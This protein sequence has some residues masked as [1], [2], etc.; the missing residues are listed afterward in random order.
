MNMIPLKPKTVI[1]LGLRGYSVHRLS[2]EDSRAIQALFDKCL[3]F[4]L[5]V[6]GH[7]AGA[8]AG[9]EE[10]QDVPPGRSPA[11]KLMLGIFDQQG[12]L[13][14]LLDAMKDY[15]DEG[16][17]WIGLLLFLPEVRS[18]GLGHVVVS[19]FAEYVQGNGGQAIML[20][21]VEE[22]ERAY[23][24]WER[25][26]FELVSKTEPRRFGDKTQTV[27]VMRKLIL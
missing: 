12:A 17:W 11:D 10:F 18:Q 5:L 1:S 21:V 23:Q 16:T 20:G 22:N 9:E 8:H 27:S 24:F 19:W 3:D 7:P 6:D 4:M 25:M 15:P 2:P 13:V 26:G 14:G